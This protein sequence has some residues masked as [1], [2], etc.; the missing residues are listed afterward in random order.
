[1]GRVA[2][3]GELLIDLISD[4][5]VSELSRAKSF[6]RFFAGSPGNLVFNLHDLGVDSAILS[7]VGDDSFG[8]AYIDLLAKRGIDV[9]YVQ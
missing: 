5:Q 2:V 8:R 3:I 4:T 1:M 9:S 7:R 6:N